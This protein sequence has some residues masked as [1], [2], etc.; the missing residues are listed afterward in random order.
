MYR[1]NE[2]KLGPYESSKKIPDIIRRSLGERDLVMKNM[3]VVR[4]SIDARR[5]KVKQVIE[6]QFVV[7]LPMQTEAFDSCL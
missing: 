4:E 6:V 3:K 7:K 5:G 1:I 2:I